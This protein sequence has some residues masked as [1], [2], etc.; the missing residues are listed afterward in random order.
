M[1]ATERH[2]EQSVV[3]LLLFAIL[4]VFFLVCHGS[5]APLS[6]SVSANGQ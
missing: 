4:P 6:V 2:T 1:K 3:F 5:A